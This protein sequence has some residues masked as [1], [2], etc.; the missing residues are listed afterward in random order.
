MLKLPEHFYQSF[1]YV[2]A[3]R[4]KRILLFESYYL[5]IKQKNP[6]GYE[7]NI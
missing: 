7:D 3:M 6:L 2:K 4:S 5:C 1:S